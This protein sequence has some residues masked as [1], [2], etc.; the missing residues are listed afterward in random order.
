MTFQEEKGRISTFQYSRVT[1]RDTWGRRGKKS[2]NL[3]DV[4]NK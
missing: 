3:F 1:T 4:I 2:Q